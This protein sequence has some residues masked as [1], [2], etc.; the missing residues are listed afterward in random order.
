M[1]N[2]KVVEHNGEL[3]TDS[4]L[5]AK[6]VG[7]EHKHLMRDIKGY[8]GI[9]EKIAESKIGFSEN[10]TES[11]FGPSDFFIPSTYKDSTGRTL[12]CYLCTKMGCDMI[13]NKLTGEKGVLFTA[14]YV[15]EFEKMKEQLTN[16]ST[17]KAVAEGEKSKQ[18]RAEAMLNN[19]KARTAN[20]YMKIAEQVG[21][22]EYKQIMYSKA[23]EVLSGSALLPLPVSERQTYSATEI[24]ERLGI[25]ANLVGK[26]A[27]ANNLKTE[28]YGKWIWD[29]SRHSNKQVE[30]FRYYDNVIPV[31]KDILNQESVIV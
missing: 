4:R 20:I 24:G 9:M 6:M 17:K 29:K 18:Q 5:V 19:S 21:I 28:Q 10:S 13:A 1:N 16:A 11:N 12:P 23:T 3:V 7:K 25:S 14:A 27:N 15:T 8:I 30:S 26:T 31:L 2:L 22:P